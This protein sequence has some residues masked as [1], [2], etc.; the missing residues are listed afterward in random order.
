MA[1]ANQEA[2]DQVNGNVDGVVVTVEAVKN[3]LRDSAKFN[4]LVRQ[5]LS[6]DEYA[7]VI[8]KCIVSFNV[9]PPFQ[10]S[11]LPLDF[12]DNSSLMDWATAEAFKKLYI[13]HVRNQWSASDAGTQ[14][15][16]HEQWEP[17][18]KVSEMLKAEALANLK[19]LKT[20]INVSRGWGGV[21]SPLRMG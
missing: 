11:C 4:E 7:Q 20:Q 5:E 8:L 21:W 19:L 18:L 2:L 16:I 15:P 14:V 17:L 1:A 9:M 10:C 6:D 3:Q 12:P 13:W